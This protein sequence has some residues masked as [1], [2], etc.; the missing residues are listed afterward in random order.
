MPAASTQYFEQM[1]AELQSGE[2]NVDVIAGDIIWVARFAANGYILDLSDR[3]DERMK[4][5]HLAG[6]LQTVEYDGKT[7]GVPWF[8][9]AGMFF[10]RRD[11]LERTG[12]SEPPA[13]W[14]EM[15]EM[16]AKVRRTSA[17]ATG[18]SFRAASAR[19]SSTPAPDPSRPTLLG[20]VVGD[21]PAVQW[22]PERRGPAGAGGAGR[23][24]A[25]HSGPGI[26]SELPPA[27]FHADYKTRPLYATLR[28]CSTDARL[29]DA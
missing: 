9:D 1:R 8:T 24:A 26:A 25:E 7:W 6:P 11:L 16:A 5:N 13:T 17:S 3:F 4:R 10:Y 21:G 22:L 15:K 27:A 28:Q 20:H 19:R 23:G 2:T 14:D 12:F 29:H 18:T